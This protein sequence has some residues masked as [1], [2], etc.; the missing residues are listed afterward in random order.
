MSLPAVVAAVGPEFFRIR[1][2]ELTADNAVDPEERFSDMQRTR[3]TA[4]PQKRTRSTP[5]ARNVSTV[6]CGRLA[7]GPGARLRSE[8]S[9]SL[10]TRRIPC[11]HWSQLI[12]GGCNFSSRGC[13]NAWSIASALALATALPR[14]RS[15]S[16]T[17]PSVPLRPTRPPIPAIGLMMK[18]RRAMTDASSPPTGPALHACLESLLA[19]S[20]VRGGHRSRMVMM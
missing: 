5:A 11:R 13:L 6:K 1:A 15:A 12:G 2:D 3:A 4:P 18:P 10:A 7:G 14:R 16:A 19:A 20:V 8:Q 9:Q 17:T